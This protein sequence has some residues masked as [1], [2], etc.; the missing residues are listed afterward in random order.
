MMTAA[1]N[2]TELFTGY[3]WSTTTITYTFI[4]EYAPYTPQGYQEPGGPTILSEAQQAATRQLFADIQSFLGIQFVEVTQD[5]SENQIGQIAIGMR[6]NI[7]SPE[8]ALTNINLSAPGDG[9]DIWL[10]AGSYGNGAA[11]NE[12]INTMLHEIGHALGLSHPTFADAQSKARYT[13][14][15]YDTGGLE[16]PTKL[17]L[18][19]ISALQYLYGAASSR[20]PGNTTYSYSSGNPMESI[21]DT[22]GNDTITAAGR[23]DSVIINLN[24]TAFTSIGFAANNLEEPSNNISIAKGAVIENAIGGNGVDVLIGNATGNTLTGNGGDDFIFGDE[25][26]AHAFFPAPGAS[27]TLRGIYW[28]GDFLDVG[29]YQTAGTDATTDNDTINAGA[30]ADWVFA[31]KGADKSMA[32]PAMISSMAAPRLMRWPIMASAASCRYRSLHHRPSPMTLARTG[33]PYSK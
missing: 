11:S 7:A 21:W 5:N 8:V 25:V 10:K 24:Q 29:D 28:D 23:S 15:S 32:A 19:D 13:V 31:G 1:Q 20:N 26:V 16:S 4:T 3:K 6:G 30:G 2:I 12:F 14:M 33:S 18:Y 22:G 27:G 17:Q 9:G